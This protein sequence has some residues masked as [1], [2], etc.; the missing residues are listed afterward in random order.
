MIIQV[1]VMT[2]VPGSLWGR[3]RVYAE[4]VREEQI[5]NEVLNLL[6]PGNVDSVILNMTT[7]QKIEYIPRKEKT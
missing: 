6:K 4:E 5:P 1:W 7:R 3:T 2:P